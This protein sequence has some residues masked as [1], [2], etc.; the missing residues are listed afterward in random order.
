MITVL[1]SE[2]KF[3]R[4]QVNNKDTYF[5]EEVK[6]LRWQLE[7][8]LSNQENCSI[9]FYNNRHGQHIPGNIIKSDDSFIT[10]DYNTKASGSSKN[11]QKNS[12][13]NNENI[14]NIIAP[15]P[16]ENSQKGHSSSHISTSTSSVNKKKIFILGDSMVKHK[17]MGHI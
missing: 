16:T 14:D 8:T 17:R 13:I 7:T 11:I 3:L 10:A 12:Y 6:F 4:D 9:R 1:K 2:I 15:T 5:H